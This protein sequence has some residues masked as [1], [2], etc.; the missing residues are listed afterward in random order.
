MFC[1]RPTVTI[2]TFLVDIGFRLNCLVD[3]SFDC[4]FHSRMSEKVA[5][6]GHSMYSRSGNIHQTQII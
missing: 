4:T 3:D 2:F 6:T 5:G 1:Q